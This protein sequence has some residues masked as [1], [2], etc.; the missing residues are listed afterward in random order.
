MKHY[1]KRRIQR[2]IEVEEN[3][4]SNQIV[5]ANNKVMSIDLGLNNLEIS[6]QKTYI[7]LLMNSFLE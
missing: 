3:Q 2:A 5:T 1:S 4:K 7:H 6:L